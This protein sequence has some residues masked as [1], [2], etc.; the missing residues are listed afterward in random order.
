MI[1]DKLAD[2]RTHASISFA[3]VT[4]GA[5]RNSIIPSQSAAPTFRHNMINGAFAE[6]HMPS[7]IGAPVLLPLIKRNPNIPFVLTT[8]GHSNDGNGARH[9]ATPEALQAQQLRVR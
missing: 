2:E 4:W 6:M 1:D 7:A 9:E 8:H 5:C 3:R